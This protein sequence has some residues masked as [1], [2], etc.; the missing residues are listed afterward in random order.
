[1]EERLR[2]FPRH[3]IALAILIVSLMPASYAL[4]RTSAPATTFQSPHSGGILGEHTVRPGESLFCIGRAYGVDPFAIASCNGIVNPNLISIGMLLEIPNAPKT[5]PPGRVCRRQFGDGTPPDGCRWSHTVVS[6]E[7]L[8]RIS[9]HYGVTMHAIAHANG[10]RNWNL[11]YV[12]QV[13]CI[14]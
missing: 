6:R 13:L 8:Y 4:A 5:L 12:G 11:I 3:W 10:I 1:M 14:P 9:L 2:K 7:N